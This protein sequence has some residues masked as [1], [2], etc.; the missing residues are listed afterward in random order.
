EAASPCGS[1]GVR[2]RTLRHR[3]PI[4]AEGSSIMNVHNAAELPVQLQGVNRPTRS[5]AVRRFPL[6][7]ALL[8]GVAIL[9][10]AFYGGLTANLENEYFH[11]AQAMV[12][13]RG[14]A[15]AMGGPSGPTAWMPPAL[16]SLE[17]A[18]LWA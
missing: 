18:L 5:P 8:L 7:T 1:A 12:A 14:F 15:D 4:L 6:V 2:P 16:P 11:I 9:A 10:A 3:A 17:A 13:G